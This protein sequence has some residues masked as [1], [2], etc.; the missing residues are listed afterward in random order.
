MT[1]FEMTWEEIERAGDR[2][3]AFMRLA[4]DA[5]RKEAE[6]LRMAEHW[7]AMAQ[8]RCP[9]ECGYGEVVLNTGTVEVL[10]FVCEDCGVHFDRRISFWHEREG[11]PFRYFERTG[12]EVEETFPARPVDFVSELD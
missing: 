7:S 12:H 1:K 9:H 4:Q 6:A 3:E 8:G 2:A 5:E 10:D 11:G